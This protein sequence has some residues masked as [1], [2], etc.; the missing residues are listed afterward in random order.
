MV[1]SGSWPSKFDPPQKSII[2]IREPNDSKVLNS[3]LMHSVK[4]ISSARQGQALTPGET[5][6]QGDIWEQGKAGEIS[7]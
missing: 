2:L 1:E 6:P 5:D 4:H 7:S 3:D